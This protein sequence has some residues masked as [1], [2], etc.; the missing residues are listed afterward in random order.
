MLFLKTRFS[1]KSL[2]L[3]LKM[4]LHIKSC[5]TSSLVF[6]HMGSARFDKV[7]HAEHLAMQG[8]AADF[9]W[10]FADP[11]KLLPLFIEE[12]QVL[13]DVF[14]RAISEHRPTREN[15]WDVIITFD[16][17]C[18]GNK[19]RIDNRRKCMNLA[20]SFKQL[21][22]SALSQNWVWLN[23]ICLRSSVIK[24]VQGGWSHCLRQ[25]TARDDRPLWL[26]HSWFSYHLEGSEAH[27]AVCQTR[28]C[29]IGRRRAETGI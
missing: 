18:P 1:N 10:E 19:L 6:V 2:S 5:W 16:E 15:P 22:A 13:S 28:C 21:G 14:A 17:F 3:F 8:G 25:F 26:F 24:H 4:R 11:G 9:K 23:P 12:S 20:M 27:V 29:L 7:V